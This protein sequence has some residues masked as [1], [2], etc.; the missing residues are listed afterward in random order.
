MKSLGLEGIAKVKHQYMCLNLAEA[1]NAGKF[2]CQLSFNFLAKDK[3]KE[4]ITP[5]MLSI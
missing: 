3:I 1:N 5:G 2:L 4:L